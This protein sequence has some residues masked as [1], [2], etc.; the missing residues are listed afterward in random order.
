MA[1]KTVYIETSVVSYL[2]ARPTSDLLPAAWQKITADWWETRRNRF[3]LMTSKVTLD[4]A[5]RGDAG[6]SARR[7]AALSDIPVLPIT[8]AVSDLADKLVQGGALPAKALNDALHVAV[9]GV[10]GVDYLLTWNY[11]HLDN[12]EARPV[13]RRICSRYGYGGPEICTPRELMGGFEDVR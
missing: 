10:H 12:A 13:I 11:R 7:L 2:T 4:E 9:S 8:G 6:A 5:G 1:K 3:D